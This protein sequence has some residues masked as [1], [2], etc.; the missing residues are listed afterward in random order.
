DRPAGGRLDRRPPRASGRSDAAGDDHA[1]AVAGP[2]LT[3]DALEAMS[4]GPG[5]PVVIEVVR[6]YAPELAEAAGRLLPQLRPDRRPPGAAG[7]GRLLADADATLL[8]ARSGGTIVGLAVVAVH[9]KLTHLTAWL[10]DVVVD[11][12]FR[13]HGAG[14]ALVTAAI[15]EARRLGALELE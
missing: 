5:R 3:R 1:T 9:R 15:E 8:A 10:E 12:A 6:A 14:T 2:D 11:E 4:A 13:G 7:L